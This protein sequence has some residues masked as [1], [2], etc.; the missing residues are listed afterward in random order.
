MFDKLELLVPPPIVALIA[1]L[2]MWGIAAAWP[3]LA[4]GLPFQSVLAGA[5]LALG[6]AIDL[7]AILAFKRA[8]TTVTPLTPEKSSHLVVTGLYRFTRNPM[9]LG[10]LFIL[11]GIAVWLGSLAN[12]AVL[13]AFITYITA[14]QISPEEARLA[15]IFGA[16]YTRY[17]Q[18]V[19]RWI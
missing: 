2:A 8:K 5:L 19:R 9:Y 3:A 16:D 6:V 4:I 14:F 7:T 10:M 1:G 15:A 12:I 17:C 13:A 11:G 18:R